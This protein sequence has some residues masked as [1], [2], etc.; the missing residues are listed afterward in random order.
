MSD[1]VLFWVQLRDAL[2]G[3]W[4]LR[5]GQAVPNQS[6]DIKFVVEDTCAALAVPIDGALPPSLSG[7]ARN[8]FVVECKG[9]RFR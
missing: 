5:I 2:T 7:W 8:A 4:T 3:L 9:N 1:P 6:P